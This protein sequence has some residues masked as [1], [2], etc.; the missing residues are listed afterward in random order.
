[1]TRSTFSITLPATEK[2][3]SWPAQGEWTYDDYLRLPD[4]GR[5]YEIIEGVLYVTNAPS[6]AHQFAVGKIFFALSQYVAAAGLGVVLTAPFEVHLPGVAK[7]VQP[8][9][10]FIPNARRPDAAANFYEGAPALV[11]EVLSPSTFRVDQSVKLAAYEQAGVTEYW[12]ADPKTRSITV[13]TLPSGG[14]EYVLHGQ[15]TDDD[16]VT[17]PLLA[18]LSLAIDHLFVAS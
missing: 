18:D 12:L 3:Y 8:D 6:Y 7:P 14:R 15:F 9:V 16:S 4:D 13:Y 17:S 10:L 11:V 5:R 1:M 2:D